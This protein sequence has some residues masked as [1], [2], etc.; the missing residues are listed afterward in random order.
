MK[1]YFFLFLL[2][3]NFLLVHTSSYSQNTI[4]G[5]ILNEE[6]EP[7]AFANIA[8]MDTVAGHLIKGTI[9]DEKGNF[10][11]KVEETGFYQLSIQFIGY[12]N[13]KQ[14]VSTSQSAGLSEIILLS[15]TN[16]LAEAVV[17][18]SRPVIERRE[19]Q[20]IF[21][22]A[23][24]TLSSGY[25][26]IEVLEQAPYV[27]VDSED[28]ILMR[29]QSA[30]IL[31][32]GRPLNLRGNDLSNYIK[33]LRSD[34]IKSIEIQ[35][36]PAA[37]TDAS[38]TGG[39]INIILRKKVMGFNSVGR[40]SYQIFGDGYYHWSSGLNF[41]YGAERWNLYGSYNHMKRENTIASDSDIF[42]YTSEN[43]L[44]TKTDVLSE[45]ERHNY[46][47]G[48]V[49]DIWKNHELG[50]AFFG[51]TTNRLRA[52]ESLLSLTNN[53]DTIDSGTTT[54]ANDVIRHV[55]SGL[56][57]YTWRIDTLN[58]TFKLIAD[59]TYQT[60]EDI[61]NAVSRYDLG[62][63]TV[64]QIRN[65][66]DNKTNVLA[67][68]ADLVK[69]LRGKWK[70]ELGAKRTNTNRKNNL[71]AEELLG[72]EWLNSDRSTSLNYRENISATYF[73]ISKPFLKNHFFKAG[74]R[75]ENTDLK[76]I[77][78]LNPDT[79]TKNYIDWFPSVFYAFDFPKESSFSA[80][81]SRRLSRPAFY[82]LNNDVRK[83]NDFRYSIGNPD[84]RP[85]YINLYELKIQRKKQ[86]GSI[87][88]RQANDAINGIYFLEDSIAF[89]QRQN[90]GSQKQFG[91]EYI[92]APDITKW[93]SARIAMHLYH[94]KY[95]NEEG[96]DS[97]NKSTISMRLFST[98]KINNTTSIDLNARYLSPTAD[99]FYEQDKFYYVNIIL[100]KSFFN[101]KLS[102]RIYL[103]DIFN[104]RRSG[105]TR[106]FDEIVTT[107]S[108]KPRS[109]SITFW[110][111][112]NFA[113]KGKANNRKTQESQ[114]TRSRI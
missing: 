91:L 23:S 83:V 55:N 24:S 27:W 114:G 107:L 30:T 45:Q 7:I 41:N 60:S 61:N 86:T 38:K 62:W 29:N 34:N 37:N 40:T 16:D 66:F 112:Y 3:V 52:A 84:L 81:Y 101:K 77:D 75:T 5:T 26:G 44:Q 49:T 21:N 69:N 25:D 85:E 80:T 10:Q 72:D 53:S 13:W 76:R 71:L 14:V 96:G 4:S 100:K 19:D 48:F 51:G 102:C 11:L 87:Y 74:L 105:N 47:I 15:K 28:N 67:I 104:T 113:N 32:N 103:N 95:T 109:R 106:P 97:F 98:F 65:S 42:Y 50:A 58:S 12:E 46:Q 70:G 73:N 33:N 79:I 78:L 88:Y 39:V 82:E 22:I 9:S 108:Q 89:H 99:A 17:R 110:V 90:N 93:W 54:A 18:A 2:L 1:N 63:F 111:T 56:L 6:Q 20:L 64:N 59:R 36:T 92:I 31:I 35:T 8:L 94:R 43:Y 57:N 68:Q